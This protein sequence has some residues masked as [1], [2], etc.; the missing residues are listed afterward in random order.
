MTVF[1]D[2][3]GTLQVMSTTTQ[4]I[5]SV[6]RVN[7]NP[8]AEDCYFYFYSSCA[9]VCHRTQ[10]SL[11]HIHSLSLLFSPS[12][13]LPP[14]LPPS[15]IR[16]TVAGFVTALLLW[17]MRKYAHYGNRGDVTVL[18]VPSGIASRTDNEQQFPATGRTSPQD[19]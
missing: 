12:D 1:L 6:E 11:I 4:V 17:A 19:A 2:L 8:K 3:T 16:E 9:K 14:S 18:C 15:Y 5:D 7:L 10:V 13:F